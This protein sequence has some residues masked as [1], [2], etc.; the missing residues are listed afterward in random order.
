MPEKTYDPGGAHLVYAG[1]AYVFSRSDAGVWT[2]QTKLVGDP[3]RVFEDFG[4][5]VAIDKNTVAVGA[6]E[7]SAG[8]GLG[9][10][11]A[12]TR[13]NGIWSKQDKFASSDNDGF[14]YFGK[15]LSVSGDTIMV[16][17]ERDRDP[18]VS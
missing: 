17:A 10:V 14:D 5:A 6:P 8:G 15:S 16:G 18:G 9:S 4:R 12:F 7:W 2:R 3:P 1:A 11:Y 13:S